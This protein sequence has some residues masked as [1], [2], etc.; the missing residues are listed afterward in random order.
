MPLGVTATA[1]VT[2]TNRGDFP[3]E[4]RAVRLEATS[5]PDFAIESAEQ[6]YTLEP[7]ERASVT[8]RFSPSALGA[9]EAALLVDSSDPDTPTLRVPILATRRQG[10]V[11]V[12]CVESLE[13]PLHR[14]CGREPA[15]DF[16]AVPVG[17]YREAIVELRSEGT[18]PVLVASV[19]F[20]GDDAPSFG[21][22]STSTGTL[23]PGEVIRLP[24]RYAAAA[25]GEVTG[26]LQVASS[27][28]PR[29][30]PL[31]GRGVEPAL[32][33]R[34]ALLDLGGVARDR[35]KT[36]TVTAS[37]C[38]DVA[39]SVTDVAILGG[40]SPFS[41]LQPL[42]RAAT[43]PP[44]AGFGLQM[45]LRFASST[46][47][48]HE[49]RVRFS[50]DRGVSVV[51][52]RARVGACDLVVTPS[53][54]EFNAQT[55]GRALLV[56]NAGVEACRVRSITITD[57]GMGVFG[58]TRGPV[59]DAVLQPGESL[60]VDVNASG[61]NGGVTG[62]ADL[63]APPRPVT[64][65]EAFGTLAVEYGEAS[66]TVI[67]VPLHRVPSV[68]RGDCVLAVLPS[69]LQFGAQEPGT[70][71]AIGLDVSNH[72]QGRC[73]L[74]RVEMAP[75][76][77][78]AF[79]VEPP[80]SPI[81]DPFL[82]VVMKVWF[83]PTRS[84]GPVSGTLK[85]VFTGDNSG[86][87]E[88]PVSGFSDGPALCVAPT[89]LDFGV[90]QLASQSSVELIACGSRA[91]TFTALDWRTADSE[92][93]LPAPPQL[94]LTLAAGQR[95][96]LEV[97]YVP[98]DA[99]GD[100][101]ILEITSDDQARPKLEVRVTGG[102][103]VVPPEAGR[104]LYLWQIGVSGQDGLPDP[105]T[106]VTLSEISRMP[107]Q[108]NLVAEPF[109][110]PR[111]GR[112]C[113]GCHSLSPDG[114]YVAVVEMG[115]QVRTMQVLDTESGLE[116]LLPATV[117]NG[118]YVSWR[119]DVN[120]DPPY[121]FVYAW[122]EGDL[123]ISSLYT[124]YIGKLAGADDPDDLET[125]P[126]WGPNGVIAYVRASAGSGAGV[127]GPAAVWTVPEAGGSATPLPGASD[128]T[129][130]RYYPAFS[131]DGRWVAYTHSASAQNSI[132]AR[133]ARLEVVAADGSGLVLTYPEVN[134]P[135][136]PNSHPS[137][138]IDGRYLTDLPPIS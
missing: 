138:S 45:G 8:L 96:T 109:F 67:E 127:Q 89:Y 2:L 13:V 44:V 70:E 129:A 134:L 60:A 110:G 107:L 125:M 121:Q 112:G 59:T 95:R 111:T 97:S 103:Q 84:A 73:T 4:I 82:G 58:L 39:L 31:A 62:T 72:G 76:S 50:S 119:P 51:T 40:P 90:T 1:A 114:R 48:L 29:A 77:D 24:L 27:D 56:A 46:L 6:T 61:L 69:T 47:G 55:G 65:D 17:E 19:G 15:V 117:G 86:E 124:G 18:D 105:G 98:A 101:A 20:A 94:P 25:A 87:V 57:D 123:A 53:E 133:D 22:V 104:F 42:T 131:R 30:L 120:A 10:P 93:A 118:L 28:G 136:A 132:S 71:R 92:I 88:V 128:Q 135:G 81:I 106:G 80:S 36:G 63:L 78:A 33:V 115:S 41:L 12:V 32:C 11:L 79:E 54:L 74:T 38:G 35:V 52:A 113:A 9:A 5:H 91:V 34:P 23:A 116:T 75:G 21:L 43:L 122:S 100:T 68:P 64:V 66:P 26:A 99:Q 16:G 49:A 137:W 85:L 83:R 102:A 126:S 108:G 14:R 130:S 37:N 3:L 7:N